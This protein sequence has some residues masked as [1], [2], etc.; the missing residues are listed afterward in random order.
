MNEFADAVMAHT[1]QG[2]VCGIPPA[3]TALTLIAL[4]PQR[5]HPKGAAASVPLQAL[6]GDFANKPIKTEARP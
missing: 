6:P 4:H 1:L 3:A 5:H 2:F